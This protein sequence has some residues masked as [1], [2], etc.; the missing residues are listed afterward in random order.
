MTSLGQISHHSNHCITALDSINTSSLHLERCLNK[1]SSGNIDTQRFSVVSLVNTPIV[2][3]LSGL[4]LSVQ[5]HKIIYVPVLES[6][7]SHMIKQKWHFV[8]T[9]S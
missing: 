9:L 4:C 8:K 2:H 1:S 5:H 6:C 7:D 3:G